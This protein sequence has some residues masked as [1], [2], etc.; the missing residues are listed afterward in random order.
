MPDRTGTPAVKITTTVTVE[1]TAEQRDAY[2]EQFG[3]VFVGHEI[4][5]RLRPELTGAIN[6]DS[7]SR[8]WLLWLV[9]HAL[10]TLTK[11]RED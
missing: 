5:A 3:T 1:L 7:R 6:G 11:P 4:A 8:D 10:V 9:R 2:A